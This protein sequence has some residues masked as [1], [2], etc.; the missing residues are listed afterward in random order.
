MRVQSGFTHAVALC[1]IAILIGVCIVIA[2]RV[3]P[4]LINRNPATSNTPAAPAPQPT[5]APTSA[6]QIKGD[7]GCKSSTMDALTLLSDSAP[8]HYT[9]VTKYIGVIECVQKGSGMF[10]SET[11]PR[12]AVGD[13]ERNA[14]TIWYAGTIAHDAGHSKLYND[15]KT[16]HP[17][18]PVPPD[19]WTGEAAERICLDAQYDALT[20]IGG[21]QVQ[22]DDVRNAITTK[23][24]EVPYSQ[25]WW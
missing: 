10:A 6:I 24:Y 18:E 8:T 20:K 25:R 21:T 17:G 12:F 1:V 11:P 14:G 7:A 3:A 19:V 5:A 2:Y 15:Y 13:N 9:T 4:T 22:L 23:Y 16:A